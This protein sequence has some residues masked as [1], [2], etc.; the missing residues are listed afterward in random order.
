MGNPT[1]V[2][3]PSFNIIRNVLNFSSKQEEVL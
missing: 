1:A 3:T 2:L